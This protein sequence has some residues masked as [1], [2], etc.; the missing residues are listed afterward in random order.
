MENGSA[1]DCP[2]MDCAKI[3]EDGYANGDGVCWIDPEMDGG[4][5]KSVV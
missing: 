1:V 4:G 3:L 5:I 2:S